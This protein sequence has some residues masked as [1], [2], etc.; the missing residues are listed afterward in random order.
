[1]KQNVSIGDIIGSFLCLTAFSILI[2]I[3][4]WFIVSAFRDAL[5]YKVVCTEYQT[6]YVS[7]PDRRW[8]KDYNPTYTTRPKQECIKWEKVERKKGK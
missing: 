8:D 3:A 7:E 5:K 4:T 1:M 6:V 2:I